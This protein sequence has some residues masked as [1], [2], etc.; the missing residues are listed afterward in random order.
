MI[1]SGDVIHF[2]SS[3]FYLLGVILDVN[4]VRQRL[5]E[6]LGYVPDQ[7]RLER[8]QLDRVCL[9]PLAWGEVE[10]GGIPVTKVTWPPGVSSNG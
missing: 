9:F 4:G 1:Q 2:T 6:S 8:T 3:A 10:E 7:I 5:L